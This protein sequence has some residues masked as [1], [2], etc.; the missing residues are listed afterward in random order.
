MK[1]IQERY[2]ALDVLRGLTVAFMIVVN[3]PGSWSDIYAPLKHADWHGCT[4]TDLVFPTFLFVIGNA[5]SFSM[6]KMGTLS[7][8]HFFRKVLQRGALIFLIGWLLNAFPFVTYTDGSYGWKDFSAI[9]L[10]GVLQRIGVC[11]ILAAALIYYCSKRV[12]LL[13]SAVLLLGYWAVLYWG[14]TPALPYTLEGNAVGKAE[15]LYLPVKNMYTHYAIPFEPLGLLSTLPAVVNVVFGYLAGLYLQQAPRA[16]AIRNFLL[17]GVGM[18][19]A[20]ACWGWVFPINKALWTST[21]VVYATGFDLLVLAVFI[22]I[23]DVYGLK[24]WSYFFEVFGKNPLFMYILSWILAVILGIIHL[25]GPSLKGIIYKHGFTSWLAP[26]NASLLYA[27][28]FMLLI[29]WVGYMMDKR[30]I[31]IRV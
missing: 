13:V 22:T 23:I 10:W 20:G 19:I 2:L 11:Y 31:Y 5:F 26:K 17:T 4:P 6:K 9:R 25:G 24:K 3:S 1:V 30:R 8:G 27:L 12:L 18:V 14:G 29:W 16:A 15:H 28:A 7:T 21:Y